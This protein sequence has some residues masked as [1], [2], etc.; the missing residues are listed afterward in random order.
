MAVLSFEFTGFTGRYAESLPARERVGLLTRHPSYD[1]L[2]RRAAHPDPA[3]RF[4][5]AAEMAEQLTGVLREVLASEDG[6]PRPWVSARFTGGDHGTPAGLPVPVLDDPPAGHQLRLAADRIGA[7]EHASARPLLDGAS[8]DWR[9]HW[10][11]GIC[12]LAGDDAERASRHFDRVYSLLPGEL[13][14]KQALGVCAERRGDHRAAARH[15]LRVWRTDR[16]DAGAAFGLARA[17]LAEGDRTGAGKVLASVPASSGGHSD[18]QAAAIVATLSG[19]DPADVTRPEVARAAARL[20][21]LDIGPELRERLTVL[22]LTAALGQVPGSARPDP[23][24]LGVPQT[25]QDLR[26]RLERGYRSLAR[27]AGTRRERAHLVEL[28]NAVRPISVL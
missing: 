5:S 7:G 15:Y 14:P 2:L 10:Y 3:E 6:C 23:P 25:E 13:A 9:V 21:R 24:L 16:G 11:L 1:R 4:A 12:A 20:E 17:R 8:R 18:A 26:R 19:R 27:L 28:A 22:I